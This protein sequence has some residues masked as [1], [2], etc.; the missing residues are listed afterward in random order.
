MSGVETTDP[1]NNLK[2]S[3]LSVTWPIF[4]HVTAMG[5][6]SQNWNHA[7]LQNLLYGVEYD[8]CCWT[9]RMLGGRAFYQMQNNTP[10][11]D[12]TFYIQFSFKGL[13]NIGKGVTQNSEG[14]VSSNGGNPDTLFNS[15]SGY[16]STFGQEI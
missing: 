4:H 14:I 8:T 6:W 3:D 11:Y 13:G 10:K 9:V 15:I 12:S 1:S 5:R 16:S 7:H 2:V